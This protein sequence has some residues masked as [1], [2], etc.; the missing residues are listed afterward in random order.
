MN[1]SFVISIYF[2]FRKPYLFY[3]HQLYFTKIFYSY[4]VQQERFKGSSFESKRQC[5]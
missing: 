2:V 3:I 5:L 4:N 1:F